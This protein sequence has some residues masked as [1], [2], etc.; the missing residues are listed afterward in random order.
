MNWHYISDLF[1]NMTVKVRIAEHWGNKN[2]ML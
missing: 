2:Y 1:G